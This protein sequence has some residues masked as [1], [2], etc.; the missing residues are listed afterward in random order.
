MRAA[1]PFRNISA[2][3]LACLAWPGT[4]CGR[5]FGAFSTGWPGLASLAWPG[6]AWL[7]ALAWPGLAWP[8]LAPGPSLAP[9][10]GGHWPIGSTILCCGACGAG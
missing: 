7:L 4:G 3:V 1:Q 6:L 2:D 8:G 9:G 5:P 10:P